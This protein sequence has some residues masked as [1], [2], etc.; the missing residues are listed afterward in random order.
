MNRL[1]LS[2]LKPITTRPQGGFV[3]PQKENFEHLSAQRREAT[4]EVMRETTSTDA[5]G[6]QT[7]FWSLTGQWT[8]YVTDAA[9]PVQV[10]VG[11]QEVQD[12]SIYDVAFPIDCD[13][14]PGDR[15]G[16]P[17]FFAEWQAGTE[18]GRNDLVVPSEPDGGNGHYYKAIAPGESGQTEPVWPTMNSGIVEDNGVVWKEVGRTSYLEVTGDNRATNPSVE[19]VVR[20]KEIR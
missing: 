15:I 3:E 5:T 9:A 12:V 11:G 18:Y 7:S 19:L 8:V 1:S 4:A 16:I 2:A 13:V 14:R 6:G 17:G 10:Q 20:A